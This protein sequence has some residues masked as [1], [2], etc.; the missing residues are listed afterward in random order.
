MSEAS[1][2]A[3]VAGRF[4][5]GDDPRRYKG[6]PPEVLAVKRM[7]REAASEAF[8]KLLAL[9]RT[10]NGAVA[11]QAAKTVLGVAGVSVQPSQSVKHTHELQPA[12]PSISIRELLDAV[13]GRPADGAPALGAMAPLSPPPGF[14]APPA[15]GVVVEGQFREIPGDFPAP[16]PSAS[17]PLPDGP[18]GKEGA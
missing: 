1:E 10:S 7:A 17:G 14:A 3:L 16:G 12:P 15:S 5:G 9:M 4:T 2:K 13:R 18:G 8:E 11:V 6:Y